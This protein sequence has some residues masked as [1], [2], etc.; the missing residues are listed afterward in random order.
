MAILRALARATPAGTSPQPSLVSL[1]DALNRL[2][3]VQRQRG[4]SDEAEATDRELLAVLRQLHGDAHPLM[5]DALRRMAGVF[6]GRRD[7]AQADPLLAEELAIYRKVWTNN[8]A[9]VEPG[10]INLAELRYQAGKFPEAEPLYREFLASR[11][12]RLSAEDDNLVVARIYLGVLLSEWSWADRRT[13]ADQRRAAA[14]RAREAVS[15]FRECVAVRSR[16]QPPGSRLP[17]VKSRLGGALLALAV[18]D[19]AQDAETRA[20]QL[21]EAERFLLEGAETLLNGGATPSRQRGAIERL[22]RLYEAWDEFAP[23]TG[24]SPKAVDWRK[25]LSDFDQATAKAGQSAAPVK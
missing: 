3:V 12:A 20:G 17:D 13:A 8:P 21:A 10:L 4:Q 5:V 1:A 18:T 16:S 23:N 7:F 24:Q 11:L 9:K 2:G 25:K 15:L 6:W 14:E 22:V 19:P